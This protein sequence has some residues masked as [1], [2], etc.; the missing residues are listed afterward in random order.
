M[1][2]LQ[3]RTALVTGASGGI[4]VHIARALA[5]AGMNVVVSGRREDALE[6]VAGELRELGVR[7]EPVPADLAVR[8]QVDS[9]IDRATA[10]IGPVDVLVN[11]AGIEISGAFARFTADELTTMIDVNLTAPMLLTRAVV[12]GMTERGQGHVVFVSSVAGKVGPAYEAPYAASKA[13]LVGL[14]QSLR[15]EYFGSA[16]GFSVICPGFVAGD[17]MYQRM[18]DEG[19]TSN[20]IIGHTTVQRIAADVVRAIREDRPEIVD[21]GTPLRPMLALG[22]LSPRTAERFMRTVGATEIFRRAAAI[23]GRD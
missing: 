13:G 6:Q 9:L 16:V 19:V 20:R 23:A 3:G 18:V 7:C 21:S 17:G 1:Q 4:G 14:T 11:N 10:A 8:E 15:G 22:Q 12:P 2:E 5:N